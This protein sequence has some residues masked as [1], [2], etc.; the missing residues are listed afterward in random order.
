MVW[1]QQQNVK[2]SGTRNC[3]VLQPR[4]LLLAILLTRVSSGYQRLTSPKADRTHDIPRYNG[5]SNDGMTAQRRHDAA[6]FHPMSLSR[7]VTV[8]NA[9][10]CAEC[11]PAGLT[12][13]CM[14]HAAT[15]D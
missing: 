11:L 2:A 1:Q 14:S 5:P 15:I 8:N 4:S 10:F 6:Y 12:L 3:A 9:C 13:T 7:V